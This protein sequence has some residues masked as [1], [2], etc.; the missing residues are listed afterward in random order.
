MKPGTQP[1]RFFTPKVRAIILWVFSLGRFI[2]LSA[3]RASLERVTRRKRNSSGDTISLSSFN[4]TRGMESLRATSSIPVFE[5]TRLKGPM[6]GLSPMKGRPPVS[7]TI[8]ATA[9]TTEG[10][11]VTPLSGG[12]APRRFGLRSTLS[13]FFTKASIPPKGARTFSRAFRT[14]TLE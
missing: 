1:K 7:L 10:W 8:S 12:E 9:S 14:S 13:P 3:S 4:S 2:T 5:A 11:V 6:A